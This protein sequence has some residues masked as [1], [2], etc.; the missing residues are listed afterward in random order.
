MPTLMGAP[1]EARATGVVANR[2]TAVRRGTRSG[3]PTAR[4][5]RI[6]AGRT[7]RPGRRGAAEREPISRANLGTQLE[8]EMRGGA[9]REL[10]N[11]GDGRA[12]GEAIGLLG[13]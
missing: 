12:S 13:F 9:G 11:V 1:T 7:P 5:G 10:T 2:G 6:V 8:R 4:A 3:T